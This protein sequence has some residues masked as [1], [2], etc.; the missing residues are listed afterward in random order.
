M[1]RATLSKKLTILGK[2]KIA[3]F[4]YDVGNGISWNQISLFLFHE[5]L[6][7][8][9]FQETSNYLMLKRFK[10][11]RFTSNSDFTKKGKN[12]YLIWQ[13]EKANSKVHFM[14]NL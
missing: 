10:D 1:P 7:N 4:Y 11:A 13:K 6:M 2:V 14:K 12:C 3:S 9:W 5:F 8:V